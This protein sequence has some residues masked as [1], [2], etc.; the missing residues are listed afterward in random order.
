[1]RR[2]T[3]RATTSR[4]HRRSAVP[5]IAGHRPSPGAEPAVR[6]LPPPASTPPPASGACA[7]AP[8]AEKRGLVRGLIA[9]P[10]HGESLESRRR[11]EPARR[12]SERLQDKA[13]E[14][15][16]GKTDERSRDRGRRRFREQG[17]PACV[18]APR[19]KEIRSAVDASQIPASEETRR[20]AEPRRRARS[21][22]PGGV[23]RTRRRSSGSERPS[24]GGGR[25]PDSERSGDA[26]PHGARGPR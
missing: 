11:A 15:S 26:P 9:R 8:T 1:M 16:Q 3:G 5:E 17:R 25:Q 22:P 12:P 14:G 6:H 24:T 18:R 23:W 19:A 2:T 21:E 7:P 13:G 10:H 20:S 4:P